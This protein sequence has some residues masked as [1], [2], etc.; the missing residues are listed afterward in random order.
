MRRFAVACGVLGI[1]V[2]ATL[3]PSRRSPSASAPPTRLQVTHTGVASGPALSPDGQT[4]AFVEGEIC[5]NA[6][7][8]CTN[9]LVVSGCGPEDKP[10]CWPGYTKSCIP[11]EP[12]GR[13]RPVHGRFVWLGAAEHDA[14][15]N[16]VSSL[17]GPSQRVGPGSAAAFST[18]VTPLFWRAR[19]TVRPGYAFFAPQPEVLDSATVPSIHGPW[20]FRNQT[21]L[22]LDWSPDGRWLALLVYRGQM[23][24]RLFLAV[25]PQRDGD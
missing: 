24:R 4:I 13:R 10:H 17:G 7:F 11:S 3:W 12:A 15:R 19:R 8:F 1:A 21:V 20:P 9:S 18:A 6:T 5:R 14:R 25:A 23:E 2:L 22:D 16:L